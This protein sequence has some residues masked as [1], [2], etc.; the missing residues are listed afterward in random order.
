MT[1]YLVT[2]KHNEYR[3]RVFR[4]GDTVVDPFRYLPQQEGVNLVQLGRNRPETISILLPS[5]GRPAS[6]DRLASS[7]YETATYP[8]QVEMVVVNDFDEPFFGGYSAVYEKWPQIR[9]RLVQRTVLSDLWNRAYER[10]SGSI[11]MHCGDDVVFQTPGWDVVVREAFEASDDKILFV[12]GDDLGPNGKTFGTH[13]FIHRRWVDAVGYFLPP[14]FSC[15]WADVW[16][17]DVAEQIDRKALLPIVTEHLHYTF[18]KSERD[19]TH[20]ER[21]ERGQ[22]DDVVALYKNTKADRVK[23]ASKLKEAM[24]A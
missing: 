15:D 22:K 18:G 1:T 23:D 11:V 4:P 21:E 24:A 7:V 6:V 8:R 16:L 20:H 12:Y 14:I 19:Q 9:P 17:N 5:R 3:D 10:S 13:G 2:T